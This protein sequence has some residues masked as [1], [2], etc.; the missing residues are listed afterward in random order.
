MPMR[1]LLILGCGYVGEKLA[2]A[3]L[4]QGIRVVGTTRCALREKELNTLGIQAVLADSPEMLSDVILASCEAVLDSIPLE[5]SGQKF[6]AGQVNWIPKLVHRLQQVKWI[7]YLSSTGVYGD[8]DGAWVDE[9]WPCKPGSLRGKQRLI[10]EDTWLN[11]GLPV[12]VFRLAGI[13]GPDRNIISRLKAGQYKAVN[14]NPPHFSS[15]IH[16]D[17]IV[18]ALLAAMNKPKVGRIMNLADDDPLPHIDYVNELAQIIGAPAPV[19]L[20]P[21]E[22]EIQLSAAALAFFADN[23]RVSNRLLHKELLPELKYPSFREGFS[24]MISS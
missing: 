17:D 22:G 8:A 9:S 7:G 11:S 23:K 15:R 19:K 4:E 1:N 21:E 12:E 5:R 18:A 3:C 16:V 10:A 24:S 13:Y 2:K 14:W 20:S 6:R